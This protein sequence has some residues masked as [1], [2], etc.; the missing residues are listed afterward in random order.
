MREELPFEDG[1]NIISGQNTAPVR[2]GD[3]QFLS[4]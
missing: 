1:M 4:V 3:I 2:E